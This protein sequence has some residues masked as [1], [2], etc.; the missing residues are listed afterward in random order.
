MKHLLSLLAI[1]LF[2]TSAQAQSDH[3][4][5]QAINETMRTER[6]LAADFVQVYDDGSRATG[7]IYIQRP[8]KM[9]FDYASKQA[10]VV[11]MSSGSVSIFENSKDWT[12][13]VY[14]TRTTPLYHLLHRNADIYK[15]KGLK[16]ITFSGN[17]ALAHYED[18]KHPDAGK[19]VLKFDR[20]KNHELVG[21]TSYPQNGEVVE[22]T[23]KNVR[24]NPKLDRN[25]FDR[26]KIAEQHKGR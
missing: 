7:Q 20:T 17:Y 16:R 2:T 9:R 21:W 14:P 6:S 15:S 13:E 8:G 23:L 12:P 18:E 11:V 19:L 10:P 1:V 26:D 3:P 24:K 25:I 4:T 22:V 5:V